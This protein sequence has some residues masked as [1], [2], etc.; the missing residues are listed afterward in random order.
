MVFNT[1]GTALNGKNNITLLA[2]KEEEVWWYD[3]AFGFSGRSS[4]VFIKHR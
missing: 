1:I 4:L 2:K 3:F